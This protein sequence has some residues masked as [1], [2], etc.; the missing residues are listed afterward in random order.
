MTGT[1]HLLLVIGV[2]AAATFATRLT[3][4]V[5]LQHKSDHPMLR[6]LGR[7]MPPAIM[8]ILVLYG[9]QGIGI[10]SVRAAL[11]IAA[12][13]AVTL[14][15]HLLL[16]HPLLSIFTGTACYMVLVQSGLLA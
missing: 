8:T 9:L 1:G 6:Y 16:R 15:L 13:S 11:A 12:A 7:Y 2:M 5:L 10:G 3:P 4:F 14:T